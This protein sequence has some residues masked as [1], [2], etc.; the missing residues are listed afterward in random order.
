MHGGGDGARVRAR[1]GDGARVRRPCGA[2]EHLIV[3]CGTNCKNT[4]Q[5]TYML[6]RSGSVTD[7]LMQLRRGARSWEWVRRAEVVEPSASGM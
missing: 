5:T 7:R 6:D 3:A 1:G 4:W 2:S